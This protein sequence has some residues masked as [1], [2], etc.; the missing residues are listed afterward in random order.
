MLIVKR[1]T[2]GNQRGNAIDDMLF[3][4]IQHS[5]QRKQHRTA[6]IQKNMICQG[7]HS[8]FKLLRINVK[9]CVTQ[10]RAAVVNLCVRKKL[11]CVS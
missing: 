8:R 2:L 4:C 1:K 5:S 6:N 9:M 3:D 10:N 7:I 11:W